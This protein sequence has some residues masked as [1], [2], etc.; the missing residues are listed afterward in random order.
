MSNSN[1]HKEISCRI[2][3]NKDNHSYYT[4]K[5]M[6]Y[7]YRETFNY[8]QC[9][10]CKCLQIV[11]IIDD[12]SKYYPSNYYSFSKYSGKDFLG[13]SGWIKKKRYD[14]TIINDSIFKKI[15]L[16]ITGKKAMIFFLI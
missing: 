1:H 2:C 6:M 11:D 14:Y 13:F 15:F 4:A 16:T 12:M 5:E 9:G 8:F 7:G 3:K 10:N